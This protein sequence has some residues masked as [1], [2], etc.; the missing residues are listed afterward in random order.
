MPN[1]TICAEHIL[2]NSCTGDLG[3]IDAKF[4]VAASSACG[5]LDFI[6]VDTPSNGQRCVEFLRK[7]QLGIATFL[8]LEKQ[9]HLEGRANEKV[10]PPEGAY[11]IL[12]AL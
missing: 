2:S 3:A 5:A 9:T 7:H 10:N 11:T 6:V 4:D 12:T 1:C 8:F